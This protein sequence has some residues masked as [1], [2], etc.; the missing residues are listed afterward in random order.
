VREFC[1]KYCWNAM[2]PLPIAELSF[3]HARWTIKARVT[4]KSRVR[5]FSKGNEEGKVFS[6]DLLDK[7]G[8]EIRATF[9]NQGADKYEELLQVGNCY[10]FSR[11]NIKIANRQ[12]NSCNHRYEITFD[13]DAIVSQVA[14]D[15][16]IQNMKLTYID[17]RSLQSKNLPTKVD[18]IGVVSDFKP[19]FAF[20]SRDGKELVKRE[21]VLADDTA[22]SMQVTIWGDRAMMPDDKFSG[23]PVISM[24]GVVV[25]E[26]NDGRS[27]SLT[28]E[29]AIVFDPKDADAD[30][31]Q[32]WWKDGGSAQ[33]I[34]ALSRE[35]GAGGA[36]RNAVFGNLSEVRNIGDS[37]PEKPMTINAVVRLATI[38]T[39]KAG[40]PQ[41]LTYMAC[42]NPREKSTLLCN[43]RVND[44]GVC[45]AC[46]SVGKGVARLN[47]RAQFVDYTS[48]AWM[49][50]FNEGAQ[51]VLGMQAEEVLA[52]ERE[53][54]P[55]DDM[56]SSKLTEALKQ[57]YYNVM[58]MQIT[59][60]A[61]TDEYQGERRAAI[62]CVD[63]KLVNR[64][65]HGKRMLGE[66]QE[67]LA[68]DIFA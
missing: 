6:I 15:T 20:T 12:Y 8:G 37:L 14:E 5:K 63:A 65:E 23:K 18:L 38:Q 47:I 27:G 51:Q 40:D 56:K 21:L 13:K 57:R 53:Q 45:P 39:I 29:G 61:K 67:M 9:F 43:R 36:V 28:S 7:F 59:I 3:I 33:N 2:E 24:K 44:D 26:W 66:I 49:T 60:R 11:G 41:P 10:V 31:I 35:G 48:S 17:L 1:L 62:S 22:T 54:V 46:G 64:V 19:S 4:S 42:S 32:R 52:L 50:T 16:E 58:P 25:K 55:D 30:R 34:A 68:C